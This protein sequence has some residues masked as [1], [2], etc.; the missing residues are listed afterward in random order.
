MEVKCERCS[1]VLGTFSQKDADSI[2][3]RCRCGARYHVNGS[4]VTLASKH[5]DSMLTS[6]VIDEIANDPRLNYS[7]KAQK[8]E[9]I[10]ERATKKRRENDI[11]YS[12]IV[13]AA[14]K[15]RDNYHKLSDDSVQDTY[16]A[17][18]RQMRQNAAAI[19]QAIAVAKHF[20]LPMRVK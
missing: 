17:G 7:T 2:Y 14:R 19:I 6:T 10:I 12:M 5:F 20:N 4:S 11:F 8:F 9:A 13:N 16:D 18:K 3:I 15:N 1:R